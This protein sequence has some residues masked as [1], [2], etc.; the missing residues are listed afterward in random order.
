[1]A[2]RRCSPA[3]P[4]GEGWRATSR[5]PSAPAWPCGRRTG[6]FSSSFS[7]ARVIIRSGAGDAGDGRRAAP[8]LL[9]RPR[10]RR[11]PRA[12]AAAPTAG[13]SD[14]ALRRRPLV[15]DFC[16]STSFR[17]STTSTRSRRPLEPRGVEGA[18]RRPRGPWVNDA[19]LGQQPRGAAGDPLPDSPADSILSAF[20]GRN[21]RRRGI[22]GG[23]ARPAVSWSPGFRPFPSRF[24][25]AARAGF[26]PGPWFRP[27]SPAGLVGAP[28]RPSH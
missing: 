4:K 2:C 20:G 23:G 12:L 8:R 26:G 9:P 6:S 28:R 24:P 3:S 17:P 16:P 21:A 25:G 14:S 22:Q 7:T 15:S 5:A 10:A 11:G 1:M 19:R 27:W 13:M 18:P